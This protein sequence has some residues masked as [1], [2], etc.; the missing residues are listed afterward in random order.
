MCCGR[1]SGIFVPSTALNTRSWEATPEGAFDLLNQL[2][3][4]NDS[5]VLL[6]ADRM[7]RIDG[8]EFLQQA[9]GDTLSRSRHATGPANALLVYVAF[10]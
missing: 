5:V 8:V 7:S 2:K 9:M 6:L 3:V 1:S 4:R 10:R